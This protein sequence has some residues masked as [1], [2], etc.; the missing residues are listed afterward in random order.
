MA[1]LLESWQTQN[2]FPYTVEL[3]LKDGEIYG[4][5]SFEIPTPEVKYTKEK[6]VVAIDTNASW[7]NLQ[8]LQSEPSSCGSLWKGFRTWQVLRVALLFS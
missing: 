3:K 8:S 6:G 1:V 5:V 7:L 4:S 2:Y